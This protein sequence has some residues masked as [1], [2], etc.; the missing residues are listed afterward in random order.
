MSISFPINRVRLRL[1]ITP[2]PVNDGPMIIVRPLDDELMEAHAYR[3]QHIE[4][5]ESQVQQIRTL[6]R[7]FGIENGIACKYPTTHLLAAVADKPVCE[8]VQQHTMLPLI[9]AM[10]LY[11]AHA[12]ISAEH[13][14]ESAF[15]RGFHRSIEDVRICVECLKFDAMQGPF[16]SYKRRHHIRGTSRCP[17]HG[18][19]L[20]TVQDRNPFSAR[21]SEWLT[22]GRIAPVP[23][24]D[25][26]VPDT[27]WMRRYTSISMAMLNADVPI[28]SEEANL[29]LVEMVEAAGLSSNIRRPRPLVS[30]LLSAKAGAR[31]LAENLSSRGE[32]VNGAFVR[33]IDGFRENP[34]TPRSAIL[35]AAIWACFEQGDPWTSRAR[36]HKLAD[37]KRAPMAA[38]RGTRDASAA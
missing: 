6:R 31:W 36:A 33:R 32:K 3:H 2:R 17:W 20:H 1:G 10:P 21:P 28:S 4:G 37:H 26:D 12:P 8:Y 24:T 7:L 18:I 9:A 14:L 34:G 16:A 19:R 27:R 29:A 30:S 15:H 38:T 23:D 5:Y 22:R 11:S 13:W 25:G 35:H